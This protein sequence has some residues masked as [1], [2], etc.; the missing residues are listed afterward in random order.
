VDPSGKFA[1]VPNESG[2]VSIYALDRSGL[3]T[4]AGAAA[5]AGSALSVAVT[6]TR[7]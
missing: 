6:G 1:Y 7:Q 5:T 3:L 2:S 4:P